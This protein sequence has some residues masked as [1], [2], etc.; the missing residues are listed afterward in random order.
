MLKPIIT[1]G[2]DKKVLLRV[3]A[4][5]FPDL[6]RLV[7]ERYPDWEWATFARFGWRETPDALVV[8]LASIDPPRPG[9]LNDR[10]SHV[11]I[12]ERYTLRMALAAEKDR[13]AVGVIHSHPK[14]GAPMPSRIDDDMDTYYARYFSDFAPGRPYVS[15]IL[16]VV[17][18]R[19]VI[20]GRVF[21]RDRWL[22]VDRTIAE[23]ESIETW[24]HGRRPIARTFDQARADRFISAFGAEAYARLRASTVAV[25]GAGG[26]GSAAIEVLARAGVGRLIIVDPDHVEASN[27]ER[28]HGTVP[29]H[30]AKRALKA[31][32]AA[33]HVRSIDPSIHVTALCGR[34]P[35]EEVVDA[36]VTA[37]VAIGCTDKQ[38]SRLALSDLAFRHLVPSI[39]CGVVLEGENGNVT[40]QVAQF[41]RFL[42]ADPCALCR[43]MIVQSRLNQELMSDEELAQR[44]AAAKEAQQRG[45]DPD[46]YW[47]AQPQINT[48]GYLTTAVGAMIGGYAI[49]WITDRFDAPFERMQMNFVSKY[50][51]V[52]DLHQ[53]QRSDCACG[54][55]RG[56][57]DQGKADALITAPDHWPPAELLEVPA[58]HLRWEPKWSHYPVTAPTYREK[59]YP[60]CAQ[61]RQTAIGIISQSNLRITEEGMFH[62]NV[63]ALS[64]L[65]RTLSNFQALIA[66]TKER[67][68]VEARV[69]ARCCFENLFMV[70]GLYTEGKDFA[71]RMKEDDKR[72][73]RGR[74]RFSFENENIFESLSSE[75]QEAVKQ[76]HE[77]NKAAPKV[78][79]LKPKDASEL[80]AF[81]DMYVIYSQFS[82]DAAHPTITALAR[83]WGPASQEAVYL[84]VEPNVDEN[85]LD[86]TLHLGCLAMIS[87]MVVVNEM[88]G[89]TDAGKSLLEINHTLKTLQ[90]EK[91]GPES[92]EE[93]MDIRTEKPKDDSA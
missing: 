24:P 1:R 2:T 39:D 83:H 84:E 60:V 5:E 36:V 19:E 93:G 29:A 61:L 43:G 37:D 38:H 55:F 11:A 42:A 86:E 90:A 44:R 71:D 10:V 45:E 80:G 28:M 4:P 88:V 69:I 7:F 50:L 81:K 75:M 54:R 62:P 9:D 79:F 66:L 27:L 40:G 82:G 73:R 58:L 34:L 31:R 41:V 16:S 72:G 89:Y 49:G 26:T 63:L 67:L 21:W 25:V 77:E 32:V 78:S 35:Q 14:G 46:P 23:R 52:T 15:L 22:S 47:R 30:A 87:M 74:I 12:D 18:G 91:W 48:V 33:E 6:K 57:A 64:L 13:L 8:T 59:L 70:G 20:S 17:D 3:A 56:W 65:S 85:Q 92:V 68:P 51:D 53:T 76:R